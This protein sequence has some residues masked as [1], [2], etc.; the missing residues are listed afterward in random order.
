MLL[1][2]NLPEGRG[3]EAIIWQ[4][5]S[6]NW[7]ERSAVRFVNSVEQSIARKKNA[8]GDQTALADKHKKRMFRGLAW[9]TVGIIITSFS[10]SV[11]SP[12]GGTYVIWW[13]AIFYGLYD[14]LKGLVGW[15]RNA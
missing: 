15:L 11:D 6:E 3:K 4:L 12:N 1:Q 2:N 7:P 10:Y 13:G 8:Q 5:T 14:F 9:T